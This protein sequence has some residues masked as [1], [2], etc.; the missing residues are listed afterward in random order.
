MDALITNF[1]TPRSTL[2][3]ILHALIGESITS[4][5]YEYAIRK[6]LRFLSYGDACL[7]WNKDG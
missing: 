1:H 5:L 4:K 3:L 6:K 7:I 2:L